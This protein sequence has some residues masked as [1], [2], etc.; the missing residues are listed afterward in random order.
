MPVIL[1][2]DGIKK[3][4]VD[5]FINE[6]C[7]HGFKVGEKTQKGYG[8]KSSTSEYSSNYSDTKWILSSKRKME[9]SGSLRGSWGACMYR[10]CASSTIRSKI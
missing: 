1:S 6:I 10:S 3:L 8:G 2:D 4:E 7:C 9:A 5:G